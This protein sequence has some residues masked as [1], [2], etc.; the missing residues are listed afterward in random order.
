MKLD[1]RTQDAVRR[2]AG[3]PEGRAFIEFLR[4]QYEADKDALVM[5]EQPEQARRLQ[6]TARRMREL[7]SLFEVK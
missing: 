1:D 6:G 3:S 4:S 5:A 7:L 2:I